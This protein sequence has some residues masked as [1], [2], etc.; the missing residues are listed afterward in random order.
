VIVAAKRDAMGTLIRQGVF[1]LEP[2]GLV[3]RESSPSRGKNL[4]ED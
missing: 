4:C 3:G 2:M 1:N